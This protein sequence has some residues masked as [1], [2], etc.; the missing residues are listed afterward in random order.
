MRPDTQQKQSGDPYVLK[1]GDIGAIVRACKAL[2]LPA[3]SVWT[4]KKKAGK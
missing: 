1:K 4:R 2:K 3:V